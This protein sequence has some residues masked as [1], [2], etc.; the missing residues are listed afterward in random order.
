MVDLL[1][2]LTKTNVVTVDQFEEV[3]Y[4][5]VLLHFV[6][7]LA[8]QAYNCIFMLC[9]LLNHATGYASQYIWCL[10][11]AGIKW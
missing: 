6:Q 9:Q 8:I 3:S 10:S 7:N 4:V 1:E 5:H 11:Q 2:F